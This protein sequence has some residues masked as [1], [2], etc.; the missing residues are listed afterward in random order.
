[1]S[2]KEQIRA[3]EARVN[4]LEVRLR[5][6]EQYALNC[7]MT[8]FD[9]SLLNTPSNWAD[10]T[11]LPGADTLCMNPPCPRRVRGT[12]QGTSGGMGSY[13]LWDDT[14]EGSSA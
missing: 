4:Q 10:C 12:A 5:V 6:L 8:P 7:T 14:P 3:L 1:M 11:C 9:P 13:K 2:K